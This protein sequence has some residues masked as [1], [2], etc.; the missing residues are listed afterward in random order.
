VQEQTFDFDKKLGFGFFRLPMINGEVDIDLCKRM[1][2]IFMTSGFGYFDVAKPYLGGQSE[3]VFKKSVAERYSRNSYILSNKLSHEFIYLG[4]NIYEIFEQQLLDCGVDYFDVYLMHCQMRTLY[5]DFQKYH[6]YDIA[7]E[8]KRRGKIR[9]LGISFHD[10]ADFLEKIL[11]EHPEIDVVQLQVNYY[12]FDDNVVQSRLCLE[13]CNKYGKPVIVMEPVK[14]GTLVD[15]PKEAD[16]LLR[17]LT[18]AG[19]N[20]S[21]AIRFAAGCPGVKM[22]LSGMSDYEQMVDNIS[23]MKDFTPLDCYEIEILK[24]VR[25]II[26]SKGHIQCTNCKYCVEGCPKNIMIPD[27]LSVLNSKL[28]YKYNHQF[29]QYYWSVY[30]YEKGKASDCIK[31]GKCEKSCPQH[32][33]VREYIN[34][35]IRIFETQEGYFDDILEDVIAKKKERNLFII[36]GA[37][38]FGHKAVGYFRESIIDIDIAYIAVSEKVER[39]QKIDGIEIVSIEEL[40]YLKNEATVLIMSIRIDFVNQMRN[41]LERLGFFSVIDFFSGNDN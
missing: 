35:A 41:N 31:C 36:Y 5:K 2:D 17:K 16:D 26:S 32:L 6:A 11:I 7:S 29:D 24:K 34:K 28:D 15:L 1:V 33:P 30:T 8:L 21:F 19:S 9:Y 13:V 39:G 37:G 20:A 27:V 18:P 25:S 22:V 38:Q 10:S 12:D 23:Y 14:A 40:T 4:Q 3:M